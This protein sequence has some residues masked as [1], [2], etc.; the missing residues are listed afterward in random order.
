MQDLESTERI[1]EDM[2]ELADRAI[3]IRDGVSSSSASAFVSTSGSS[4]SRVCSDESQLKLER[5]SAFIELR[6]SLLPPSSLVSSSSSSV[7]VS[8]P[9]SSTLSSCSS[10]GSSSLC[11]PFSSLSSSSFNEDNNINEDEKMNVDLFDLDSLVHQLEVHDKKVNAGSKYWF[12]VNSSG[13]VSAVEES[14]NSSSSSGSSLEVGDSKNILQFGSVEGFV[15][16]D[17]SLRKVLKQ[18][19][20]ITGMTSSKILNMNINAKL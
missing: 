6:N 3:R 13:E 10:S 16:V 15:S 12:S 4:S 5:L 17:E 9:S 19:E 7:S 1:V 18:E 8:S 14:K 2:K 11:S 20:G